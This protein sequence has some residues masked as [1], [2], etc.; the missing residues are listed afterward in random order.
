MI[1]TLDRTS[2]RRIL[3]IKLRA[4]GDVVLSTIVL[5]NLR[6]AFPHASLE[7]L[8]EKGGAGVLQGNP[9]IDRCLVYDRTRMTGPGLIRQVRKGRYDL[10][11]DLFGNP[12][13]ALLTLLSG[14]QYR[15]GYRFRG[16]TYAYNAVVEP[17]GSSV[18]NTQFNLDALERIGIPIIDRSLHIVPGKHDEEKIEDFW[19]REIPVGVAV[20]ALHSGGGWRTKRWPEERFAAVAD[21]IQSQHGAA[22]L[23]PWGPG[24]EPDV[25]RIRSNMK[26]R[27]IIPPS[28]TLL[29]LAA[30]LRRCSLVVTNDSGPMHIAAAMGTPVVGIFGPTSPRLQGPY[31]AKAT[32]VRNESLPCLGCN[33]VECP[34]GNPCMKELEVQTVLDAIRELAVM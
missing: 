14:A 1:E 24:E 34:I 16:R 17:R 2:V 7:F 28:T 32:T 25:E 23:L 18:H 15:V 3:V 30:L 22:I 9:F 19:R 31:G 27:A 26:T 12:R 10:V 20:V 11:I 6:E 33:L 21:K 4:V 5:K 29:E 8:T 13:T